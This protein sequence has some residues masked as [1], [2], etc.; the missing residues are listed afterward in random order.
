MKSWVM[1]LYLASISVGNA[2]TAAVNAAINR[3]DGTARLTEVQYM[4]FF[5]SLMLVAA[6][7]FLPI[8]CY[9]DDE[10]NAAAAPT[11]RCDDVAVPPAGANGFSA[12]RN[13]FSAGLLR[14]AGAGGSSAAIS[15][16][17]STE[18]SVEVELSSPDSVSKHFHAFPTIP[19]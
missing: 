3:P 19:T 1:A 6:V 7:L 17:E 2:L 5:T 16:V 9:Y 18:S 4:Q 13:G 8:I 11:R 10:S 15:D 14:I 12:S